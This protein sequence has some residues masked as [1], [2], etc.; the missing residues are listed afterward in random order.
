MISFIRGAGD[1]PRG[2]TGE[3][4]AHP[5]HRYSASEHI[6]GNGENQ[7][8]ESFIPGHRE[9]QAGLFLGPVALETAAIFNSCHS[10][11]LSPGAGNRNDG[12]SPAC[13]EIL[14]NSQKT[15]EPNV[16]S[17]DPPD[18]RFPLVSN[19]NSQVPWLQAAAKHPPYSCVTIKQH[20]INS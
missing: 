16:R 7:A 20:L 3:D 17:S 2:A 11:G 15:S 6:H 13:L 19:Q 1:F 12:A 9:G 4:A 14:T 10:S 5:T 8:P 18:V